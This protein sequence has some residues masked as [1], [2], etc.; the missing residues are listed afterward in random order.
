MGSCNPDS[1]TFFGL[2][3]LGLFIACTGGLISK[4]KETRRNALIVGF[5][6]SFGGG[7][8]YLLTGCN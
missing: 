5:A 3:F 7:L 6:V 8:F 1:G 2:I 4:D